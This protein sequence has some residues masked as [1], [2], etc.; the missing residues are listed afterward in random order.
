MELDPNISDNT[1]SSSTVEKINIDELISDINNCKNEFTCHMY[2]IIRFTNKCETAIEKLTELKMNNIEA[3]EEI[4]KEVSLISNVISNSSFG[5]Y[6]NSLV[7][8]MN[9]LIS[10]VPTIE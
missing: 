7:K 9:R 2:E 1:L 5:E 4:K 10:E 3:D 8:F 6:L